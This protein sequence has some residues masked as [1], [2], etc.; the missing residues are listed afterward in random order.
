[1]PSRTSG[2]GQTAR[3]T[4]HSP[5]FET[6]VDADKVPHG[7]WCWG[8]YSVDFIKERKSVVL[9]MAKLLTS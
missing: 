2:D 6:Q 9:F 5:G 4:W 3:G 7:F 8:S 1:M